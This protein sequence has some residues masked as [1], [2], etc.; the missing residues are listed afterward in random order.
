MTDG[1][2]YTVYLDDFRIVGVELDL[3]CNEGSC[4][5]DI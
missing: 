1:V 5:K 4:R 3:A 2:L